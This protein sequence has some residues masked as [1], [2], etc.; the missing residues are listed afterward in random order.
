MRP[1]VLQALRTFGDLFG[2][3]SQVL[4][5]EGRFFAK[6]TGQFTYGLDNIDFVSEVGL[7]RSRRRVLEKQ[8]EI[9]NTARRSAA[10]LLGRPCSDEM[11]PL[12]LSAFVGAHPIL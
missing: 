9:F 5:D 10:E 4:R 3:I 6:N 7:P 2:E 11:P 8:T 1:L 12:P